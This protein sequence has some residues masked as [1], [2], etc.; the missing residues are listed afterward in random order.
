M[1]RTPKETVLLGSLNIRI[2]GLVLNNKHFAV[3]TIISPS[4]C[5]VEKR[6]IIAGTYVLDCFFK[7]IMLSHTIF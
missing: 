6:D 2:L 7:I 3:C 4:A 5:S 1:F